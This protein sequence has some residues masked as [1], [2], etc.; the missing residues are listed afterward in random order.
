MSD[1]VP[2]ISVVMSVYNGE[3]FVAQSI[4]SVLRQT[5]PGFELLIVNDASTDRTR[6]IVTSFRDPRIR[7]VDNPSNVGLTRSLNRGLAL[8]R[9]RFVAR[10]D[11]DDL[12][13]PTRLAEQLAFMR[14]NP[15]VALV[16]TQ[17][18]V[19]D[20]RGRVLPRPGWGRAVSCAAIRFGAIR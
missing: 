11:A 19:M 14:A 15:G 20:A 5:F 3:Q 17:A 18:R 13:L 7:I 6:E 8:A 12:S 10:Q 9:G 16:G 1:A 2:A 4:E